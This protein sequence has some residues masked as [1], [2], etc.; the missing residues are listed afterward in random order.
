MP[1]KKVLQYECDRCPNVWYVPEE[2]KEQPVHSVDIDVNIPNLMVAKV[3]YTCLCPGCVTT[4]VNS[5]SSISKVSKKVSANRKAKKKAGAETADKE[6]SSPAAPD[7][8]AS[9]AAPAVVS[10]ALAKTEPPVA[11][12]APLPKPSVISV[13]AVASGASGKA[14]QSAVVHPRK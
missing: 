14:P 4:I 11:A 9:A 3:K 12:V 1:A 2:A 10:P 7:T 8:T 5:L 13:P 6:L